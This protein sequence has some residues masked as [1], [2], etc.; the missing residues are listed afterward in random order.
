MVLLKHTLNAGLKEN[1]V[2]QKKILHP[3]LFV[4]YFTLNCSKRAINLKLCQD[5]CSSAVRRSSWKHFDPTN[6]G[7]FK[8]DTD[9]DIWQL[10]KSDYDIWAHQGIMTNMCFY[11]DILEL[12]NKPV[13][14]LWYLW[15]YWSFLSADIHTDTDMSA[16]SLISADLSV[17]ST[18]TGR[19]VSFGVYLMQNLAP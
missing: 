3:L 2:T 6:P 10:I 16:I 9:L 14:A 18:V 7:F 8:V 13:S 19:K 15:Q 17:Q 5:S 4:I 11:W 12:K 1:E